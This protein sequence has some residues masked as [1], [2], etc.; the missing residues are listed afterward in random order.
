M[1]TAPLSSPPSAS[2]VAFGRAT[3][4][5]LGLGLLQLAVWLWSCL[6]DFYAGSR[7][8]LLTVHAGR[9]FMAAH[10]H[11][12][13]MLPSSVGYYGTGTQGTL[14]YHATALSDYLLFFRFGDLTSIDA[15]FLGGLGVYLHHTAKRLPVGRAFLAA[16][17]QMLSHLAQ[18]TVLMYMLRLGLAAV[19]SQVFK[20]KTNGL[21]SLATESY[22]PFYVVMGLLLGL[23]AFLLRWGH[24]QQEGGLPG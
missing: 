17:S 13:S 1:R 12:Y 18:A 10:P 7:T 16:A 3:Y 11:L 19:A 15:L 5:L 21:F 22:S 24:A 14:S 9:T 23:C 20:A 8:I 4:G 6:Y 2:P